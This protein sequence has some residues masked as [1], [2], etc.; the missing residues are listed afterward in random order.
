MAKVAN[1][2]RRRQHPR[3]DASLNGPVRG[4]T[5]WSLSIRCPY[6]GGT[7]HGRVRDPGVA[8]GPRR[9]PCGPAFVVVRRTYRV[10]TGKAA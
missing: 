7:H 1:L 6:C 9:L 2:R 3:A 8:A 5:L 10:R 4:R